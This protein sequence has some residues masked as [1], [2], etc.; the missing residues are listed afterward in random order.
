MSEITL[1]D[2]QAQAPS[3]A[4]SLS[5]VGVTNVEKVIR[6][7]ANGA[8]QLYSAKLDCFVDLGP[9]CALAVA[10]LL[11]DVLGK[12][13]RAQGRLAENDLADSVVDDLFEARHVRALLVGSQIHEAVELRRVQLFGAVRLDPDD[14]LDVRHAHA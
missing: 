11:G 8:E 1:E 2:V 12:R 10:H 3:L 7:Q 13:L 4:I 5:R 14:L 9:A 6:I